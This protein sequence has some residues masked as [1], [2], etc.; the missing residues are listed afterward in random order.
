MEWGRN[1]NG[2]N[3]SKSVRGRKMI[4][5]TLLLLGVWDFV[6]LF[7]FCVVVFYIGLIILD[8]R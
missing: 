8:H 3:T 5:S 2:K 4:I 1:K 7:G 6:L